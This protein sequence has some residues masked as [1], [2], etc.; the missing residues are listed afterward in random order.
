MDGSLGAEE[1]VWQ[2]LEHM[3]G[4]ALSGGQV[5]TV[6]CQKYMQLMEHYL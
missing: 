2:Q 5:P 6:T 1:G 4:V 3:E